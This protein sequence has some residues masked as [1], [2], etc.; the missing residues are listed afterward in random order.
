M[1][2]YIDNLSNDYRVM[3][4]LHGNK[5]VEYFVHLLQRTGA[6]TLPLRVPE[7]GEQFGRHVSKYV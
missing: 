3:F 7:T 5:L 1:I 4:C 2:K 6:P